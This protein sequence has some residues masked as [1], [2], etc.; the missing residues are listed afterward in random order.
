M[1][2]SDVKEIIIN[3]LLKDFECIEVKFFEIDNDFKSLNSKNYIGIILVN[4]YRYFQIMVSEIHNI[5]SYD[6][7]ELKPLYNKSIIKIIQNP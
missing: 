7:T 2:K 3:E 4:E 5:I 1:K 6:L